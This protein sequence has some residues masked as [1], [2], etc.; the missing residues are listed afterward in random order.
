[1]SFLLL[2]IS[3]TNISIYDSKIPPNRLFCFPESAVLQGWAQTAWRH[4]TEHLICAAELS[5]HCLTVGSLK[6]RH[7]SGTVSAVIVSAV[8]L[9]DALISSRLLI[10]GYFELQ[11]SRLS[12]GWFILCWK[13]E[14]KYSLFYL[15][16]VEKFDF[17]CCYCT[18]LCR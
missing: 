9:T 15:H 16:R 5:K 3:M 12:K 17:I 1:M 6:E 2:Q 13:L 7:W 11:I 14:M 4:L 8:G 10:K 18:P